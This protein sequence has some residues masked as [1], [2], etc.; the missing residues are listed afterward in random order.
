M[1][2]A[3]GW[4]IF[5]AAVFHRILPASGFNLSTYKNLKPL[6]RLATALGTLAMLGG[7]AILLVSPVRFAYKFHDT[8]IM[9]DFTG[10]REY[11][12]LPIVVPTSHVFMQ[13]LYYAPNPERYYFILDWEA[14]VDE[15]SGTFSPQEFKHMEAWKRRYPQQFKNVVAT[16]EFLSAN[17]RFLVLDNPGHTRK[18]SLQAKGLK[19]VWESLQCPQWVEMRLI[20]NR[21]YKVTALDDAGRV[22]YLLVEK[23]TGHANLT[24]S[25]E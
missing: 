11:S 17:S 8:E 10:L 18:C 9:E 12:S 15:H 5:L 24:A 25:F 3:L 13:N 1:P 6:D 16:D 21:S 20:H 14:A 19:H 23:R 2:T 22:P 7:L 4:A